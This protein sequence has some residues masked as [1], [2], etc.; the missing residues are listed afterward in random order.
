MPDVSDKLN[1]P[2]DEFEMVERPTVIVH[3]RDKST[4]KYAIL[5]WHGY[6]RV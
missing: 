3:V 1:P 6:L 2:R 5:D 4:G